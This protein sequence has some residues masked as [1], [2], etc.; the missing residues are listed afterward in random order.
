MFKLIF[1]DIL[2]DK[3]RRLILLLLATVGLVATICAGLASVAA[4]ASGNEQLAIS[5]ELIPYLATLLSAV[6]T[7]I[8]Y[9]SILKGFHRA[10]YSVEGQLAFTRPVSR[11]SVLLSKNIADAIWISLFSLISLV[12]SASMITTSS[13]SGDLIKEIVG[14]SLLPIISENAALYIPL[15]AVYSITSSTSGLLVA[16][17]AITFGSLIP[18][19]HKLICGIGIYFGARVAVS[20]VS[21]IVS[22]AFTLPL[23]EF[24][25]GGMVLP[26]AALPTYSLITLIISL[27]LDVGIIVGAHLISR[28]IVTKRLSFR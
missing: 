18:R 11:G 23:F 22:T 25:E 5:L 8:L 21:D 26:E 3:R 10:L 4:R 12:T 13:I 7:V 14:E 16:E 24:G 20:T 19:N 2:A 9:V 27:A 17:L 15:F 6:V 1:H 28:L